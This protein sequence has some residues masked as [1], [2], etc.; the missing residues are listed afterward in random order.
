MKQSTLIT[1]VELDDTTNTKEEN[2]RRFSNILAPAYP[3][4]H[5]ISHTLIFYD[6]GWSC[7]FVY[8]ILSVRV[9]LVN[10]KFFHAAK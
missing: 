10:T 2:D 4:S 7:V 8:L 9:Q 3:N 1:S 5:D 6:L